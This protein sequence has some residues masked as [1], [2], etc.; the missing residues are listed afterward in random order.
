ML[1][2]GVVVELDATGEPAVEVP[3]SLLVEA[4]GLLFEEQRVLR[5]V[6]LDVGGPEPD[7]LVN[8][9]AQ[10]LGD[11][12]QET[13]EGRVGP[14]G[15]LRRPE[16]GEEAWA[17]QR[18]FWGPRSTSSQVNELLDREVPPAT[19]LA[20]HAQVLRPVDEL[21]TYLFAAAPVAP[22][23]GVYGRFAEAFDR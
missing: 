16:V 21:V 6:E 22:E 20:D 19:Q 2:D 15:D 9:F 13:V 11:V 5:R 10:Y 7:E 14:D 3:P 18:H 23:V 1:P 4:A 12:L 17:R 8:F